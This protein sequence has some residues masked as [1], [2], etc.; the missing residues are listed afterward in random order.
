[1]KIKSP[2]L[3]EIGKPLEIETLELDPPK[4]NE[5][6]VKNVNCG[7]CHSD[8][9][10]VNGDLQAGRVP[11]TVGHEASGVVEAVGPGVTSVE[12]GDH[13]VS[14]F[15]C[16]CG[17]C[18]DCLRGKGYIC[19]T[20]FE[21]MIGG[22]MLDGTNRLHDRNGDPVAQGYFA[23][24]FASHAVVP[25]Q[26]VIPVD[27]SLPHDQIC[28]LGCC[29]PTGYGAATTAADL[30]QTDT[31]A[32]WGMGGVGLNVVQGAASRGA[33]PIIAVDYDGRKERIARDFGATHFIDS[34]KQDPVAV[35]QEMTGGGVDYAFEVSGNAGAYVQ[36][37]WSIGM[38]GALVA[39][40]VPPQ[41]AASELPMFILPLQ[42]KSIIGTLYGNTRLR[43][44]IPRFARMVGDGTLNMDKLVTKKFKVEEINDVIAAMQNNEIIGRWV[45]DLD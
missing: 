14:T 6:L 43:Q 9:S 19:S 34:S 7:W 35:I 21:A 39:V 32:V 29:V 28:L 42:A 15:M 44:D 8:L 36:A 37:Y 23:S 12:V 13:V 4:A 18:K 22:F 31:V 26:A 16:A 3:R 2:V 11:T 25:E 10:I 33:Y 24:G 27:K 38:G 17:K 30:H 1:M 40:G 41:E 5:V 20:S 45:C